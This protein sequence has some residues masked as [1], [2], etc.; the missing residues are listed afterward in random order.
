MLQ[1]VLEYVTINS[2]YRQNTGTVAFGHTSTWKVKCHFNCQF[3]RGNVAGDN[4]AFVPQTC[5]EKEIQAGL[6][7][8]SA[9]PLLKALLDNVGAYLL[10]LN[11]NRQI[12]FASHDFLETFG[13]PENRSAFVPAKPSTALMYGTAPWDAAPPKPARPAA[14]FW[15][16]CNRSKRVSRQNASF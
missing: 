15:L 14:W 10:V 7:A 5:F 1:F 12:L 4:S 3:R 8:L 11:S 6:E 2:G 16:C 9:D 13:N